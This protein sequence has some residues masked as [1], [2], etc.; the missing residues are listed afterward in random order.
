MGALSAFLLFRAGMAAWGVAGLAVAEWVGMFGVAWAALWT[1]GGLGPVLRLRRSTP[2]SLVA[3]LLAAGAAPPLAWTLAWAQSR[4]IS[5]DPRVLELMDQQLSVGDSGSLALLLLAVAV[6]PAICEELIFR[7]LLLRGMTRWVRPGVSVVLSSI[8]FGV[9]HWVPG[10]GFRV[11]PLVGV[12]LLLGWLTLRAGSVLPAMVAHA[13]YNGGVLLQDTFTRGGWG[14]AA[15]PGPVA[16]PPFF[17]LLLGVAFL[18]ISSELLPPR[19][20]P[21]ERPSQG[22]RNQAS[23]P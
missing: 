15:G 5:P 14:P 13:A 16:P 4:W 20:A 3:G 11:L 18:W 6:T 22:N 8:L 17:W 19:G 10:G 1:R 23:E 2:A 9:F 7:G 21:T 12:G